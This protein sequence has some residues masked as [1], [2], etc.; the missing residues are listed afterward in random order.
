MANPKLMTAHAKYDFAVDGGG[1][2]TI[3]PSNSAII[4]DNAVIVRC[5]SLVTTA[6]TSGG[7]ATLALTAG[8]VT[9]KAATAFD[10]GAFDD[11]DVTEHTVTDKTTSSTGIQFVIATAALTAGVV[12]VYVEYYLTGES[13]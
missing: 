12:E 13:A 8:G 3:V 9:L 10:N 4:P 2:G 1:T 6:M 7:S 11:E 5:Y